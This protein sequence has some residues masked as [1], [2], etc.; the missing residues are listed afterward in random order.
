MKIPLSWLKEYIPLQQHP[1]DI[2]KIL[3]SLGIEVESCETT[4][5]SFEGV[6]V[7]KVLEI[8][9]HPNADKLCVAKVT[10]GQEVYQVVCGAPNC[11]EGLKTAFAP[12]GA[13]LRETGGKSFQIK[14]TKIRGI[15][16][17]GMLC[18]AKEL[19]LSEE[20][21]GIMELPASFQEGTSLATLYADT[22][23][24]ISLTP[25]LNY[26]ASVIGIA[27]E[28]S[29]AT[30]TPL[31]YPNTQVQES[32][33]SI[34]NQV[35]V[36]IEDSQACPRYTC[37]LIKQVKIG[38]S[39]DWLRA[40]LEQCEIRSI[41]N[42]VDITN[43]VLLEM[44]HPLHAF[45]YDRL[46]GHQIR[47]EKV[48]DGVLF[49]TLDEKE[50][51]LTTEDLMICDA[52]QPIAIAGIMGGA[53]SEVQD[54]TQV[55]LLES[56]YFDPVSIRKTSKRLGLQTDSSKRFERGTDPNQLVS[57]LDRATR[58]IQQI[59][60]GE[61]C[62]GIIDIKKE[63]F[64]PK[65]IACRINRIN[66]VLGTVLSQGEVET[67]FQRLGFKYW[68]K[69]QGIIDVQ[70]PT[71]RNDIQGEIDLIEE[72]ARLYGYHH[73]PKQE[74]RYQS[75]QLPPSSI[76]QFE[77]EMRI[78]FIKEGLQEFLTCDLIGPT[79]LEIVQQPPISAEPYIHVLNPSSIEQSILRTSLLPGL[80]Q[81]VKYNIDHQNHQINGFEIGRIHFK[82][83]EQYKEQSVAA[84]ILSG[85]AHVYHWDDKPV[86]YDF[87]DLKGIAENF[88]KELNISSV[89]YKNLRLPTFHT[90]RQASLFVD[91]L[92][93]GSIGEIHPAILR[94]LDVTQKILFGE[95]NLQ[96][97]MQLST[98]QSKI[99]EPALYPG[100]SRDWTIT[101]Q[102][103]LPF[104][105]VL[106]FIHEQASPL[107]EEV[108]LLDIYHHE[109]LGQDFHNVTLHFVYRD[110]TRT[111][112]QEIVETEH[113]RLTSEVVKKL[114]NAVKE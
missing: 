114:G 18:S 72:V 92:E 83:G 90:G 48:S 61:V 11:R 54:Q 20:D 50:H 60:G 27:R 113:R 22:V 53:N 84:I 99:Q 45:D 100:S 30:G 5:L 37:R 4:Q 40:R 32:P 64:I 36:R 109:K 80:L 19:H 107:L 34:E 35:E 2:A 78:Q 108:S 57:S 89:V 12:I 106:Q 101:I 82:I 76:Y 26:C 91:S 79:L 16:S 71:Y 63:E 68:T 74:G 3:I 75:S 38:P 43:Y 10:D 17:F 88:L 47:V 46:Q 112:E 85:P 9:S 51:R 70:V 69:E 7:G 95:F 6:R 31:L 56:A 58:L 73:I 86:V 29:A 28:L 110:P 67:I 21:E 25:N 111:V 98:Y 14:K 102:K 96:D 33:D 59:A 55:I 13:I 81:V 105:Q 66:Q 62:K 1:E 15:E 8:H 39:P 104:A 87:F 24:D 41:N 42:V 44:G 94:R 65:R 23:F 52:A 49:N 93:I 103:T 77:E 97:L